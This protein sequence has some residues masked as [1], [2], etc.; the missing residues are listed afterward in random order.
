MLEG[1]GVFSVARHVLVYQELVHVEQNARIDV[2]AQ[3]VSGV[4]LRHPL[5]EFE[6]ASSFRLC[7]LA[8][9]FARLSLSVPFG[10]RL[11]R[12]N[13]VTSFVTFVCRPPALLCG[14]VFHL[15]GDVF[16]GMAGPVSVLSATGCATPLRS[17]Q[18]PSASRPGGTLH[19]M[20]GVALP[21]E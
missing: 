5:F 11:K 10:S 16:V 18:D 14:D 17:T 21:V 7:V 12:A 13:A 9:S 3:L 4:A 2:P 15:C 19:P 1:A 8:P 6:L 20:R